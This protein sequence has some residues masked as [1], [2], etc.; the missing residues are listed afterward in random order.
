MP[1]DPA[2]FE[3]MQQIMGGVNYQS[4]PT[5]PNAPPSTT[6]SS[7]S[8]SCTQNVVQV[9][10]N[11]EEDQFKLTRLSLDQVVQL[12][13]WLMYQCCTALECPRCHGEKSVHTLLVLICE[14]ILLMYECAAAR[15]AK[16]A[17]IQSNSR[18]ASEMHKGADDYASYYP[19]EKPGQLFCGI[20]GMPMETA[21][22]Q[23]G[24][25]SP[26]QGSQYTIEEQ[27]CMVHA[28]MK[29]H[30]KSFRGLLDWIGGTC[31]ESGNLART[32]KIEALGVRLVKAGEQIDAS[33]GMIMNR[34]D[35]T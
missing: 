18:S 29:M 24:I 1:G 3:A 35:M 2:S 15:M 22:C 34:F 5:P 12:Q 32:G 31:E 13:K 10:S 20:S 4:F 9:L 27:V 14:R 19:P 33:A 25:C 11:I 8:C 21:A 7:A 30:M 17:Q 26:E 28:L 23:G 16:T 6:G